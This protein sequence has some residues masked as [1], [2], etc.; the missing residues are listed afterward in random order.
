MLNNRFK[1]MHCKYQ[2]VTRKEKEAVN[3]NVC[4]LGANLCENL[5]ISFV[6]SLYILGVLYQ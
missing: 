5:G 6:I 1:H 4:F 2:R 3:E